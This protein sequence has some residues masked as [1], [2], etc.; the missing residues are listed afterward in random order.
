MVR[1][2]VQVEKRKKVLAVSSA[3]VENLK[4]A[5][6][7]EFREIVRPES[8]SKLVYQ[9]WDEDFQEYIDL[10]GDPLND[11]D[12]VQVLQ[13]PRPTVN[14]LQSTPVTKVSD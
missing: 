12:K 7:A 6:A 8:Q 10:N 9:K 11:R 1:V 3:E 13:S 14:W 4:K 5:V 2:L